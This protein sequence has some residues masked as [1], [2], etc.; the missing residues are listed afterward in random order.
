[1]M[2]QAWQLSDVRVTGYNIPFQPLIGL[3]MSN[4]YSGAG[5]GP[6]D[7]SS[8][9]PLYA[10]PSDQQPCNDTTPPNG[11]TPAGLGVIRAKA[12]QLWQ[13]MEAARAYDR[14]EW[15][16]IIF[17]APN[18]GIYT[19]PIVTI[20]DTG[21]VGLPVSELLPPD[22]IL[23]AWVHT[24]P[25]TGYWNGSP[26]QVDWEGTRTMRDSGRADPNLLTYVVDL[27]GADRMREYAW[28]GSHS[29]SHRGP[30]INC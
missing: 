22:C 3:P 4:W 14:W 16:G 25:A 21:L 12:K 6:A 30:Q 2:P 17:A 11:T 28:D 27:R 7:T 10:Q 19:S 15:A 29:E 23:L 8:T 1:M 5:G 13:E 9:S 20:Q 18:G 24:H 26:S